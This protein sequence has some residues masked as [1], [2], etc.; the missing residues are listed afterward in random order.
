MY[1][2]LH[3]VQFQICHYPKVKGGATMGSKFNSGFIFGINYVLVIDPMG[4]AVE[5]VLL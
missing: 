5:Q 4:S 3:E 2:Y 1:K